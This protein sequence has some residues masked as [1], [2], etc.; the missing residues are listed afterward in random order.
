MVNIAVYAHSVASVPHSR[1]YILWL[2]ALN[3]LETSHPCMYYL[4]IVCLT[5]PQYMLHSLAFEVC[6]LSL[7]LVADL[8]G[9]FQHT[10]S[11]HH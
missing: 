4:V 3:Q 11:F 9:E 1:A 7:S 10:V 8:L 2:G 6:S 5:F